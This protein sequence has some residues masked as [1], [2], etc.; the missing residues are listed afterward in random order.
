MTNSPSHPSPFRGVI[1][2][3]HTAILWSVVAAFIGTTTETSLAI[4]ARGA[5]VDAAR[6]VLSRLL[7][8]RTGSFVLLEIPREQGKDLFE[9]AAVGGTVTVKGTDA[10]ALCRGAYYYLREACNVQV[11]WSGTHCVLP[12]RFPDF[13]RTRVVCP[14]RFRQY[15]NVCTFGYSTVWW[16]WPRWEQELDWMALHGINMPL[17]MVGEE[18]V[19]QRVWKSIGITDS[20]LSDYFTGPAFLPWHRM[21][22]V[23]KHG[24]PLP[25][26]W[27]EGQETLQKKILGRMR[28]LDMDPVVPAFSGFV[29]AAFQRLHPE[30]HVEMLS[31]WGDFPEDHRTHLLFPTSPLF[32]EI[33]VKFIQEYR[34]T[35]GPVQYYLADSF[36]E[37]VVPVTPGGRY[38]ELASFGKG[39]YSPIADADPKGVWV[40][41]GWLF[42]NDA[43]FWD[44][45]SVRALLR[46][47]PDDRMIILDLAN[48]AFHGWKAQHGFY[49]KEWIYSMI[50]NFGGN[51][52]LNGNLPVI[53]KDPVES[54]KSPQAGHR[55]GM[56]LAPEGIENNDVVYELASDMMWRSDTISLTPWLTQY[57][58]SRYGACPPALGRAWQELVASAYGAGAGNILHAF[59]QRPHRGVSGNV[60]VSPEF[61][62][63]LEDYLSCASALGG[64][65]LYV[66]DAVELAV[67][68]LGGIADQ[69]L[70]DAML[71]HDSRS[72]ELRDSLV[73]E[74]IAV[75]EDIDALLNTRPDRRMERWVGNARAWGTTA[76]EKA[77]YEK[78]AKLQVTVWGGPDLYDYASKL[79]SGLVR[80]FYLGRWK[81][82]FSLLRQLPAGKDVPPDSLIAWEQAWTAGSG[83]SSPARIE[84]PLKTIREMIDRWNRPFPLSRAPVILPDSV[85]VTAKSGIDVA[86]RPADRSGITR[87]TIDGSFPTAQSAGV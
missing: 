1:G 17:A 38:D 47:V 7:G 70:R 82:Y 11:T 39:V 62:T 48:E 85:V 57:A 86:I 74:A 35:F 29:P 58:Q 40:M 24:G 13:A 15:F 23:N 69:R 32:H 36:N 6:G 55:V 84:N 22:N 56:G 53:A 50:H 78:N 37:M 20:E 51:N 83:L 45:A 59:Q 25:Q 52:P 41:Q 12:V 10:V 44:T 72:P 67:Q 2:D 63:A 64:E 9:V 54:L 61:Q 49:G 26:H 19:W 80:D 76:E 27:I 31:P 28:E 4:P 43:T 30:A 65:Q 5:N 21:G 33:G 73:S 42:Y 46:D 16:D 75:M 60:N 34:R 14:N 77:F 87:Y 68:W 71:A 79:W 3:F 66:D 18:A 81:K 8:P